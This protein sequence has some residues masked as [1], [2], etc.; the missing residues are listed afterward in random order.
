[1]TSSTNIPAPQSISAEAQAFLSMGPIT[2]SPFPPLDDAEAWR[3]LVSQMDEQLAFLA[4]VPESVEVTDVVIDGVRCFDI[5]PRQLAGSAD[6]VV[7]DFH[8]GG[9]IAGGGAVA[10]GLA[11]TFAAGVNRH[12][13]SVDYRMPPDHPYPAAL[14]DC[15]AVYKAMLRD[16]APGKII[17]HGGSAG[18]NLAAAMVL[19]ARDEGLPMPAG[20]ILLTPEVDL[21]ES[22]DSFQTNKHLDIILTTSLMQANL[23]YANGADLSHPY[24]SPLFGDFSKGFPPTF[25]AT[26]TRDLFLSNTVRMH[27]A[28]LAAGVPA[29]LYVIEAAPHGG[30]PFAPEGQAMTAQVARFINN[31][32][33]A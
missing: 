12:F 5:R 28:L 9:L 32:W 11:A 8:S 24:L 25:L 21:T 23:L 19:R 31:L 1:M 29:E 3:K 14:D 22:G 18:G 4:Q 33:S 13:I 7:I 27:C 16:Y 15:M 10:R 2:G 30:F 20:V 17:I 26:G 6:C